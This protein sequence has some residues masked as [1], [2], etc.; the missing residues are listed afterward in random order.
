MALHGFEPR[1][2]GSAESNVFAV[3]GGRIRGSQAAAPSPSARCLGSEGWERSRRRRTAEKFWNTSCVC[4]GEKARFWPFFGMATGLEPAWILTFST[5]LSRRGSR[6]RA[7]STPPSFMRFC[8]IAR[9]NKTPE[10]FQNLEYLTK[11]H[12]V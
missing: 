2:C 12:A 3:S 5:G 1:T 8:A 11:K 7:P 10:V 4:L 9:T 6:V